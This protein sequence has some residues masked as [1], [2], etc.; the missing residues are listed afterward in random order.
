MGKVSKSLERITFL[1]PGRNLSGG[2]RVTARMA[3]ELQVLG[4]P[5]RVL[6]KTGPKIGRLQRSVRRIVGGQFGK[7]KDWLTAVPYEVCGVRNLDDIDCSTDRCVISV[8]TLMSEHIRG[9]VFP[10][11]K[12]RYCHGFS[13]NLGAVA[14]SAWQGDDPIISVSPALVETLRDLSGRHEIPVVPNGIDRGEYFIEPGVNRTGIGLVYNSHP[15]KDPLT[16]LRV[17]DR[18]S[19]LGHP[20]YVFGAEKRPRG[21]ERESYSRAPTVSQARA[22][23]N[24]CKVWIIPSRSEG[25]CL[26]I[27]EAMACGTAVVSTDHDTVRGLIDDGLN[28]LLRP[29]GDDSGLAAAA[30][31]LMAE[32]GQRS[33]IVSEGLAT[34]SRFPWR[35]A[36][37]SLLKAIQR[38]ETL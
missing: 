26:P 8:G 28:G 16:A 34:V 31:A 37:E 1:L 6:Y 2:V 35:D 14:R 9:R 29:V 33:R 7:G 20:I 4:Q 5:V 32:E 22:I 11:M 17:V 30:E 25:F 3:Q 13:S 19:G 10:C 15:K 27:L 24:R 21:I 38:F 18:L 23:Y 12:I 36:A